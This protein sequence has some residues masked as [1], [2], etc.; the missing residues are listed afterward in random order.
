MGEFH[1]FD[2]LDCLLGTTCADGDDNANGE[3]KGDGDGD[4][5]QWSNVSPLQILVSQD[6][7]TELFCDVP[8][9]SQ[10]DLQANLN[11]LGVM[12]SPLSDVSVLVPDTGDHVEQLLSQE[13]SSSNLIVDGTSSGGWEFSGGGQGGGKQVQQ[14]EAKAIEVSMFE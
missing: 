12:Q 11:E 6:C 5:Q 9:A 2:M 10:L 1:D 8:M 13:G 3:G 4:F 7:S 14:N